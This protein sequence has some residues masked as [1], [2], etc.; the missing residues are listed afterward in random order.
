MLLPSTKPVWPGF[1]TFGRKAW[2]LLANVLAR[3][4]YRLPSNVIGRQFPSLAWSPD[5][6]I[7][8]MSPLLIN[9]EVSPFLSIAKNAWSKVGEISLMNS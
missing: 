7:K 9:S 3:I 5:L 4:L 6:G 1:I 8:V 2:S